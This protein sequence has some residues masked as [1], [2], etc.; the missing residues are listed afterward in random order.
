VD[1]D[2]EVA[3]K[4]LH[5]VDNSAGAPL[6]LPGGG[7][8]GR[9]STGNIYGRRAGRNDSSGMAWDWKVQLGVGTTGDIGVQPSHS[10]KYSAVFLP[11]GDTVYSLNADTG[12]VLWSAKL[13]GIINMK[14]QVS[15]MEDYVYAITNDGTIHQLHIGT[16][17]RSWSHQDP[18]KSGVKAEISLS[19]N[20]STLF[21]ATLSGEITALTTVGTLRTPEPT[22]TPTQRLS[23]RPSAS[24]SASPSTGPSVAPSFFP[25]SGPSSRPSSSP[26]VFPSVLPS[27]QPSDAPSRTPSVA[28]SGAPSEVPSLSKAPSDAPSLLPSTN[29]T[30]ADQKVDI[31][32][33]DVVIGF[34]A[35]SSAVNLFELRR[36]TAEHLSVVYEGTAG[37]LENFRWVE[38][39]A[40]RFRKQHVSM[41]ASGGTRRRRAQAAPETVAV[42]TFGGGFVFQGAPVADREDLDALVRGAFAGADNFRYHARLQN[43]EDDILRLATRVSFQQS[44]EGVAGTETGLFGGL[45]SG[46]PSILMAV[47]FVSTL[48]LLGLLI[49]QRRRSLIPEESSIKSVAVY[50]SDGFSTLSSITGLSSHFVGSFRRSIGR[51]ESLESSVEKGVSPSGQMVTI[52]SV[53][54]NLS[55]EFED[56]ISIRRISASLLMSSGSESLRSICRSIRKT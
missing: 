46:A 35:D 36:I 54:R 9:D 51:R 52:G 3:E 19:D 56:N 48:T 31:K 39:A 1:G 45:E 26:S 29:P 42:V 18:T 40:K 5:E 47:A 22:G 27:T 8:V 55:K 25:S 32:N 15:P 4:E 2:G 49:A 34:A 38:L 7:I 10:N 20:G 44:E 21:Y 41:P 12:A 13:T 6:A 50:D 24:P 30:A 28:P 14:V 11:F 17:A 16:G 23:L 37:R 33:F 53:Q 43:A